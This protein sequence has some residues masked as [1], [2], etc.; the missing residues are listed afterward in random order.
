MSGLL[1]GQTFT[2]SYMEFQAS[3]LSLQF[4]AASGSPPGEAQRRRPEAAARD[5]MPFIV[6]PLSI[7]PS[8]QGEQQKP[9]RAEALGDG[10]P[11]FSP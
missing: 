5:N 9:F 4:T 10:Q 6:P 2:D 3:L 7:N 8:L 11:P 1:P